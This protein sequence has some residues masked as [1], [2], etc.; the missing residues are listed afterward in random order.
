MTTGP[1][2]DD[3]PLSL[4]VLRVT[5]QR[6]YHAALATL[7][8]VVEACPDDLWFD[9]Q[10]ANA[11]WQVAYHALFF[12]HL[13][14][15]DDEASFQPWAE[16]VTDVQNPDGLGPADDADSRPVHP[17]PYTR[18][19]VLAYWEVVDRMVDRAVSGFDLHR[20]DSGFPWYPVPKLEH[21]L[22]NLRH[23]QHHAAQLAD[24]LRAHT[25]AGTRWIATRPPRQ[26][27]S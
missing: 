1:E 23:V 19:Q 14:L 2:P 13:Y 4:D 26:T 24:R 7:R 11:Y 8:D 12:T 22:I 9:P 15:G 16:H 17:E 10:P 21:Q 3:A 27:P 5:L 25:G 20:S 6:Q 18:A